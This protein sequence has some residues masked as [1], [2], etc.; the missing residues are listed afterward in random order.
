MQVKS[1]DDTCYAGEYL[2][3][4]A[5][6]ALLKLLDKH[7]HFLP[8]DVG[9]LSFIF[10]LTVHVNSILTWLTLYYYLVYTGQITR[11]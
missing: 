1:I 5:T 8:A 10:L 4:D 2:P 9:S 6:K 3:E 11:V 7:C